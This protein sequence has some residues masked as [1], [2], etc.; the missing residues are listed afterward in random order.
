MKVSVK[1]FQR[2]ADS[3]GRLNESVPFVSFADISPHSG[4]STLG[5]LRR[6]RNFLALKGAPHRV[7]SKTVQWT[8]FEEGHA[9]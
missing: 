6:E 3:K 1:P 2:L 7:N 9:L 5:A 8:V 4:E